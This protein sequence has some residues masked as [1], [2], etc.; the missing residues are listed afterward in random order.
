MLRVFT[1]LCVFAAAALAQSPTPVPSDTPVMIQMPQSHITDFV[2]LYRS[3]TH[4]KVWID[5]EL[6][7]D[8]RVS[9]SVDRPMP[10]PEAI[11]LI[12]DTLRK[13]GVAIREVGDTEAYVSRVAP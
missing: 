7:F 1:V 10:R 3:L 12:R 4:R 5:A 6:R 2:E 13:E 8:Q 9:I 11:S